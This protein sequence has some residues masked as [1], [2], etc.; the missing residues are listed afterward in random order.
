[1]IEMT[2]IQKAYGGRLAVRNLNLNIAAGEV[3]GFLGPNGAGKST[4]LRMIVGLTLPD[5]GTIRLNGIDP[6]VDGM[7]TKRIVGFIPDRPFL[8]DKLTAVEFLRFIGGLYQMESGDLGKRSSEL[9]ELFKLSDRHHELVASFSH[10]MKQRLIMAAAL[11]HRPK[12]LVVDEPMVG[13]DP[14]GARLVK[15]I[16]RSAAH[17]HGMA[18]FMSTHSLDT[19]EEVCDRVGI[20]LEG[21]LQTEGRVEDLRNT[22]AGDTDLESIFLRLTGG[23]DGTE[24]TEEALGLL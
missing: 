10:G 24:A 22:V 2:N 14:Q 8:Y 18:V 7:N 16:F 19:A 4:T 20:L 3:Y 13:L 23:V 17:D 6:T 1:M 11:L 21:Q 12:I 15:N 9:L 5:S